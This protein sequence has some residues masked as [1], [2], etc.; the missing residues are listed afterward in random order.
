MVRGLDAAFHFSP[1]IPLQIPFFDFFPL[2]IGLF[3]EN[4]TERYFNITAP[5]IQGKWHDCQAPLL[6]FPLDRGYVSLGKEQLA[7]PLR[8][9]PGQCAGKSVFGDVEMF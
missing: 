9:V 7:W 5:S 8:V 3:S 1:Q 6:R 2:V 4:N